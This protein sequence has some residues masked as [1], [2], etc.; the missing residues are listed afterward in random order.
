V[1][2]CF[3]FLNFL[4]LS[5]CI[6]K[7]YKVSNISYLNTP[8]PPLSFIPPPIPGTVFCIY[9]HVY[10][11]FAPYSSLFLNSCTMFVLRM[12]IVFAYLSYFQCLSIK[13]FI[14]MN[15]LVYVI[16]KIYENSFFSNVNLVSIPFMCIPSFPF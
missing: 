3:C 4:P 2:S 8:P 9:I 10:T 5:L 12:S 16:S 13:I 6:D 14:A 11:L 7:G 1:P 15:D